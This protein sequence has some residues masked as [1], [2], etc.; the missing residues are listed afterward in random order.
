MQPQPVFPCERSGWCRNNHD[1]CKACTDESVRI[2]QQF[3]PPE[4]ETQVDKE[5]EKVIKA[6]LPLLEK[7]DEEVTKEYKQDDLLITVDTN[8]YIHLKV[9]IGLF[10]MG[11][12]MERL[13]YEGHSCTDVTMK[14]NSLGRPL[15]S[16]LYKGNAPTKAIEDGAN[17]EFHG[18]LYKM[19][20]RMKLKIQ[21]ELKGEGW[22]HQ[23]ESFRVPM[24]QLRDYVLPNG[25]LTKGAH[26]KRQRDDESEEE[27]DE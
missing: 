18:I 7:L 20:G 5:F 16:D 17:A 4:W 6:A 22:N 2:A 10:K 11:I 27:E 26:T 25:S 12:K 1:M 13:S 24:R 9:N 14:I 15:W 19:A 21:N 23:N 8:K 3:Y